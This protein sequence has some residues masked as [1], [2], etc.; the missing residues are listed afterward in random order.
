M[1][2]LREVSVGVESTLTTPLW[3]ELYAAR[4][5]AAAAAS[6]LWSRNMPMGHRRGGFTDCGAPTTSSPGSPCLLVLEVEHVGYG[7]SGRNGGW[8]S[9]LFP[10]GGD[11]PARRHGVEATRRLLGELRHTVDE[12]GNVVAAEGFP[13]SAMSVAGALSCAGAGAGGGRGQV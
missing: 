11:A 8:V 12:V 9:A 4:P 7:A 10:L 2:P 13:G 1:T 5:A 6:G 3:W